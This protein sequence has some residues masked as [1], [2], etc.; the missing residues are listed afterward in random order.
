MNL[1]GDLLVFSQAMASIQG[2][3]VCQHGRHEI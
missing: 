2:R 1:K 3:G